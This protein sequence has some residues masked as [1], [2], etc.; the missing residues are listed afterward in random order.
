MSVLRIQNVHSWLITP[1]RDIK[2]ELHSR[3]RFRE[4]NYYHNA[5]YKRG[6]WDGFKE[7][8]NERSG[9][10]LSGLLPEVIHYLKENNKPFAIQDERENNIQWLHREIN[11]T[12]LNSW[13]PD[14]YDPIT[15][16]DYQPDLVNKAIK[17]NRGLIKAP[18]AAGKTF[19]MIS[20]LKC[21]PKKT[22]V[23]F[24]TKNKGLVHQNYEAMLK[25]GIPNVGRWYGTHKEANYIMC[26]TN[27]VNTFRSIDKLLPKFK[28]LIVD[29]VHE[30]MSKV[31]VNAY[32]K[33]KK[34]C[35]RFGVS[36]TP[37]KDMKVHKHLVKAH[38]GPIFKTSTTES[39]HLT[40]KDLQERG[41]LSPSNCTFYPV[42]EPNI[43]YE[44]YIDAVTL[45]I[46]ENYEFHSIIRRLARSKK[47]R[48]LILVERRDQGEYLKQLMPEAHW[49]NGSDSL[50]A[51]EPVIKALQ[52]SDNVTA[53]VMRHIITAG[54]D[55][56]IH[57]LI[58]AAGGDAHYNVIQQ[59]GRGL[60]CASD[61]DQL[62]FYDFVFNINDYL[63]KHSK[64]RIKTLTDEGHNVTVKDEIDF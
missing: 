8:F 58:N 16:H 20:I 15:L 42:N 13:L 11:E 39:G 30:C 55:I 38:F 24:V 60:R 56:M 26:V 21:L 52:S 32:K 33:M 27:N 23:L 40:T 22:P 25:W 2:S 18:T 7:F 43:A 50:K 63:Y 12:F 5:A 45:G 14:G 31:P 51:R 4:K 57:N 6:K 19:I 34:A 46:A 29:E 1:D 36:A 64:N 48:T 28:V 17:Y 53:I 59:I 47:G 61:K 41:I 54:I 35:I 44:P 62:E 3:L 37:F 9:M 49:I 10:F